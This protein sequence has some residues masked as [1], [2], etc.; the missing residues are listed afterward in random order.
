MFLTWNKLILI[1]III[2]FIL[3]GMTI[4]LSLFFDCRPFAKQFLENY[5]LNNQCICPTH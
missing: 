5:L 4:I 2:L 1:F 3:G